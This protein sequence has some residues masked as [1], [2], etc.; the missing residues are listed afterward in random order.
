MTSYPSHEFV[1]D[2]KEASAIFRNVSDLNDHE[3]N[4]LDT[5]GIWG[6]I[7]DPIGSCL[8][9]NVNDVADK[10]LEMLNDKSEKVGE[11]EQT[12]QHSNM[13]LVQQFDASGGESNKSDDAEQQIQKGDRKTS[14]RSPKTSRKNIESERESV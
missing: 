5:D 9:K 13:E 4:L 6:K 10:I 1:I 14:R 2:R 3:K 7:K 12:D 8:V 11:N